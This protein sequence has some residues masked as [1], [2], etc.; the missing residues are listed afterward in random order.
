[1]VPALIPKPLR[2]EEFQLKAQL[3]SN[4]EKASATSVL[5]ET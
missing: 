4:N 1:M 5:S 2:R 3:S